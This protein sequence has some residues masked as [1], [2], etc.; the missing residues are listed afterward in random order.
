[1]LFYDLY[2][3]R[4]KIMGGARLDAYYIPEGGGRVVPPNVSKLTLPARR[5][6]QITIKDCVEHSVFFLFESIFVIM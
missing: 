2:I 5:I 3:T 6:L 1:M 4:T